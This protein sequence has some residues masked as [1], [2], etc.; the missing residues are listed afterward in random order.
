MKSEYLKND[1]LFIYKYWSGIV[2]I[3]VKRPGNNESI[4]R[5]FNKRKWYKQKSSIII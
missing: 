2:L 4:E 3:A 5:I 1:Y